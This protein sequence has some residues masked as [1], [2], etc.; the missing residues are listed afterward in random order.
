M[1]RT[2][3][4]EFAQCMTETD[5]LLLLVFHVVVMM[6]LK[7]GYI[8]GLQISDQEKQRVSVDLQLPTW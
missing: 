5:D 3:W 1:F 7:S 4:T 6:T 2:F 8:F